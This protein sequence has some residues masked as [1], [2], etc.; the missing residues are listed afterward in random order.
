MNVWY[1]AK[2]LLQHFAGISMDALHIL[3][4]V[5][6]FIIFAMLLRRPLSSWLPWLLVLALTLV[7]EAS[8]LWLEQWPSPGMQY[9]ESARDVVLTMVLPT[10][11]LVAVRRLPRLFTSRTISIPPPSSGSGGAVAS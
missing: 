2:Q 3:V 7:N 10:L 1:E 8:D 9:G 6:A 4:G 5:V 11:L